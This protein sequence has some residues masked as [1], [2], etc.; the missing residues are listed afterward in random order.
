MTGPG[1]AGVHAVAR[2]T[3]A[4]DGRGGTALP[5]LAGDGPLAL[6]RVPH[7]DPAAAQVA[8]VGAMAAP[9]GGDRLRIEVHVRAGAR[10]RVGSTAA[11]ISLPSRTPAP[12]HYDLDLR[13]DDGAVLEWLPEP[14]VAATGSELRMTTRARIAPGGRLLLREEQI[15]GRTGEPPGRISSRLTVS[16][17][18]TVLDQQTDTGVPGRNGPA[19]LADHRAFGQLLLCSDTLT[20]SQPTFDPRVEA[21]LL[22]LACGTAALLTAVAPDGLLL[23][24]ALDHTTFATIAG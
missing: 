21:A 3:A 20:Y 8:V 13:I 14:V 15:L 11:T 7:P 4:P 19:V 9:L 24:R 5:L 17:P 6:R 23:R 2:I 18:G 10:L 12:A 22:P 16:H 1:P